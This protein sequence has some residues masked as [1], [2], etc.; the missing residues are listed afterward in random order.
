IG[1]INFKSIT[2]SAGE[3]LKN[4]G[5]DIDPNE[6]VENLPMGTRQVVE[7]I[8]SLMMNA[9]IIIFDEPT[10]SLSKPEKEKLFETIQDLKNKGI[11]VLFISHIL[12]DVLELCDRIAV[13]RDG[14]LIGSL[15]A[16][17]TTQNEII[18]M[19]V[20]RE[21]SKVYPEIDKEIR[22]DPAL[23]I[24][25]INQEKTLKDISLSVKK[26][27]ILGLYGIIGAG[28]TELAKAIFGVD[29]IDS[30]EVRVDGKLI[31]SLSPQA[32]ID[33]G[34]AFVTED[35]RLEGL[36]MS[37]SVRNNIT[38]IKIKDILNRFGVINR[39]AEKGFS[40]G[41]VGNLKIKVSDPEKQPMLNLSGGNQQKV[42]FG[43]WVMNQP[44]L[45]ILDEPTRGV[46]VG[47]KYE[48]YTIIGQMAKEG[49]GILFISS[50][51]EELIGICDRILVMKKGRVSGEVTRKDFE[52]ETIGN[53]AL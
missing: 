10:T 3:Y 51:M 34:M 44:D 15:D 52:Q 4:Y 25:G 47:A 43:K 48:I 35:R 26:G 27:E 46:D 36:L 5:L 9:K 18:R 6:K 17:G 24:V 8:K 37:K 50:E 12:E 40:D 23:E 28:R 45:F 29:P 20:G 53:L 21:L 32:C 31:D 42:V 7:I 11:S 38:L 30:G 2:R 49:S 1:G 14:E 16:E 13:L 33:N 22:K 41:M 39:S 19:M